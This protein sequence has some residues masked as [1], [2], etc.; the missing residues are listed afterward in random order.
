MK[1]AERKNTGKPPLANVLQFGRALD[2][3]AEHMQA[4]REKYPDVD[5]LPNWKLG[6]KPDVEYLDSATRHLVALANGEEYDSETRTHHAAA[7][8]WNM[9]ALLENNRKLSGVRA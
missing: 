2:F 9:L 7:V 3:L 6:G 1:K 5:G 4:G 8:A